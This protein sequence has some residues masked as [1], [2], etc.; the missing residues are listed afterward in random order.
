MIELH[1]IEGGRESAARRARRC[2]R[3]KRP[4]RIRLGVV[5][6]C[7]PLGACLL[8]GLPRPAR[9][10]DINGGVSF[11][12]ILAGA[13]P[14]LAVSPHLGFVWRTDSGLLFEA[15]D[16]GSIM[17][18]GGVL[19][20]GVY[21]QTSGAIGYAWEKLAISAGPA[22]SI[23]RMPACGPLIC[24]RVIGLAPGGNAE[25]S[26]YFAGALGVS[27]HANVS[28]LGG[29]S[30]ILPGGVAGMVMAGPILRWRSE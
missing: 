11:G 28:W 27:I 1:Q 21:N 22:L 10:F 16:I 12:G 14:Y 2:S 19:G 7:I 13:V 24:G 26:Y 5:L 3:S 8:I 30:T 6:G 29:R 9:A 18:M 15:R 4:R 25:V 20:I 23:Y 17:P